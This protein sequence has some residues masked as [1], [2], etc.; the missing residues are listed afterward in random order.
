M[1]FRPKDIRRCLDMAVQ[2]T[3]LY[4]SRFVN[5]D[6]FPRSI[7]S[8]TLLCREKTNHNINLRTFSAM[9][10]N[11]SETIKAV[12]VLVYGSGH[13]GA[14]SARWDI[15][16]QKKLN[17][18]WSRFCLC[19]ELFHV[20]LDAPEYRNMKLDEHISKLFYP[21]LEQTTRT[22]SCWHFRNND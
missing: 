18:C 17:K 1:S 19:K 16:L 15:F 6:K 22:L 14:L 21:S 10:N 20:L 8:F 9:P 5:S 12:C 4:K 7:E 3:A 11:I 2:M 13:Y